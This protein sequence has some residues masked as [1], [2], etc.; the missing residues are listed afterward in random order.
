MFLH[1]PRYHQ[2]EG[3]QPK[4]VCVP[5]K[6]LKV[7]RTF[8]YQTQLLQTSI[9]QLLPWCKNL[10]CHSLYCF[11]RTDFWYKIVFRIQLPYALVTLETAK[12]HVSLFIE[13][14]I[15]SGNK[16]NFLK[17]FFNKHNFCSSFSKID[18]MHR[19]NIW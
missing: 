9:S 6:Q 13:A 3:G 11:V 19:V 16:H 15:N 8:V 7:G 10:H 18:T 17:F 4:D 14:K 1:S 5:G 12:Y 2:E